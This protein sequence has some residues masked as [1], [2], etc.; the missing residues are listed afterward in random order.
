MV[1]RR[2]THT[3]Q[4]FCMKVQGHIEEQKQQGKLV[5]NLKGCAGHKKNDEG[6]S[7]APLCLLNLA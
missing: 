5:S 6:V 4:L 1:I 3:F 2:L 7:R